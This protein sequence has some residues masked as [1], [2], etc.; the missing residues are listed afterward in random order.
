ML[1]SFVKAQN[2]PTSLIEEKTFMTFGLILINFVFYI[3]EL[4]L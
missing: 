2:F 3:I 4:S 1:G